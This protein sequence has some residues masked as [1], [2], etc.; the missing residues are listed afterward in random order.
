LAILVLTAAPANAHAVLVASSPVD[1]AHLDAPPA[2]V[3]LTFDEAVRLVPGAAQVIS[4]TGTRADDGTAHLSADGSTI[5][6]PL[7]PELQRGSYAA[8]FRVVSADTH[9]VSGSISFGVGQDAAA[10]AIPPADHS[11]ALTVGSDVARGVL[12]FGLVLGAGVALVC[13]TLWGWAFGLARIRA[14]IGCGWIL[15]GLATLTQFLLLGP[16]SLNLGWSDIFSTDAVSDTLTSRAGATLIVRALLLAALVVVSRARGRRSTVALGVCTA[17][18]ALTVV[19][20]GH[21]GAGEQV[22]LA[23]VVTAAH[24]VAM[25]VWLGGLLVLCVAVIPSRRV[26]DLRRWSLTAFTCVSV[27]ILSGEYQAWRQV[28]PV[29]AMWSTGYGITLS[30][31]L[32]VVTGMLVLAC[33]SQRHLDQR[34]LRRTVPA[35]MALGL[36]VIIATTALVSQAPARTTYGPAVSLSAPLDARSARIRIDTTR[37]GPTSIA[38]TAVD[39]VDR[40]VPARSVRGT[41]SSED[42]GIAALEVKFTPAAD[43]AWR[44]SYAVVPLPG[45]WTLILTIEFSAADAVV[46]STNFRVW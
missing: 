27:L 1:G 4:T 43:G 40:L 13:R 23:T 28:R 41:L 42:A 11:G 33:I 35:E 29:E 39:A 16:Q 44:S 6:I 18:L 24:V 38:V 46:T 3:T 12:Y 34:L 45:S 9:I 20:D 10:P 15:L 8:T 22:W 32:A 36:A 19:I 37:R 31:K 25:T 21:A 7:L 26:D 2:A 30:I 14:L 17:V 5:V